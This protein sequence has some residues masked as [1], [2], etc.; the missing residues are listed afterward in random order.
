MHYTL[1]IAH[2]VC[3]EFSK[4]AIGFTTKLDLVRA[5]T[6]SI[7]KAVG[8]IKGRI[9]FCVILDGCSSE[10]RRIFELF[11]PVGGNTDLEIIQTSAVG[12]LKTYAK[13]LDVL[14]SANE[15]EFVYFSEDDYLYTPD[16]F[17]AMIDFMR[18]SEVDFVTPLDHPDLYHGA[19]TKFRE[20]WEAQIRISAY[21]HW[22]SIRSTC[23]TFMTSPRVLN[24]AHSILER[25]SKGALD[26]P[27]WLGITKKDVLNI[28]IIAYAVCMYVLRK[29]IRNRAL[30]TL[31]AWKSLGRRILKTRRFG[32]WSPIPTLAVHLSNQ[33]LPFSSQQFLF[34]AS[35]EVQK[36][37]REATVQYLKSNQ[38]PH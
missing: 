36:Q 14:L 35:E 7:S 21:G 6:D 33:S 17:L 8:K 25:Y 20:K 16:A 12:N 38:I 1:T 37:I 10:Y 23:L 30:Y 31:W 32:L 28:K 15:T 26:Y 13:Q 19:F 5:T 3:P 24:E 27:M 11:F 18:E 29:K 9:R 2:R 22:Q 4:T 34:F